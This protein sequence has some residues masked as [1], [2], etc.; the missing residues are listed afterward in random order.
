MTLE[1]G[2]T[3][4]GRRTL[5]RRVGVFLSRLRQQLGNRRLVR[6]TQ[7][8]KLLQPLG[9]GSPLPASFAY[10]L[11]DMAGTASERLPTADPQ[12]EQTLPRERP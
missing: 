9:N 10:Q 3:W 11:D 4:D 7:R 12:G 6:V 2:L 1:R 8:Y 5:L